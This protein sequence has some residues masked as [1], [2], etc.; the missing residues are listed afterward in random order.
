MAAMASA[1]SLVKPLF[2]GGGAMMRVPRS[3]FP[4]AASSAQRR[5]W[6]NQVAMLVTSEGEWVLPG[7]QAFLA[8]LGDPCPDYDAVGFAVKNLGFIKLLI[9]DDLVVE[10][11]LHPRNVR[12][13]ALAALERQLLT[14]KI[15]LFRIKYLDAEWHSEIS[16]SIEHTLSRLHELCAPAFDPPSSERFLIARQEPSVLFE[17]S[18]EQLSPSALLAQKW[19]ASFGQFDGSL[20]PFAIANHLLQRVVIV[21]LKPNSPDPTFRFIGDEHAAWLGTDYQFHAIGEKME[22]MPDKDYGAWSSEFYKG[23]AGSGR[24]RYDHITAKIELKQRP[25]VTHYE[26][27]LLPWKTGSSEVLVTTFSRRLSGKSVDSTS[28]EPVSSVAKKEAKSS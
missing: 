10:I 8:A 1:Q 25:Y 3:T 18:A 9:I 2:T 5:I 21:G 7:S 28:S 26:R 22:N 12:L 13:P 23:V 19:R 6:V 15:T 20:L 14:S 4:I 17:E 24:P 16:A 11:E 27:L